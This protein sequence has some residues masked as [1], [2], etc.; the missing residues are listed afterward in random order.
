MSAEPQHRERPR[1]RR[2]GGQGAS[3]DDA[4]VRLTDVHKAFDERPVLRGV[5][6]EIPRGGTYCII[7]RSGTGKSVTLKHIVGL[8]R[9]DRGRVEVFGQDITDASERAIAERR[10]DI[11]YLFQDGALLGWMTVAENIGL[12]LRE[13]ERIGRTQIAQRVREKLALVGLEDAGDKLPSELSGGMRKRVGLARALIRD[14]QLVLYDEPTSG[15]DPV[16]ANQINELILDMQRQLQVTS[17]VVTHDMQSAYMVS[18]RIGMLYEGRLIEEGTPDE[19]QATDHP[20]VR[21]F[22]EGRT[23]GPITD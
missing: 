3:D 22:I 1:K 6:L 8:L 5:D 12:P 20:V 21:Q 15:L 17:I 7:G 10:K 9:P 23:T 13:H 16:M 14:P 11:G 2:G 19:I 4:L 18:D